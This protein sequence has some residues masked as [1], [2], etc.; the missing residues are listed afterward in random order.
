MMHPLIK[1]KNRQNEPH[2]VKTCLRAYIDREEPN[3]RSLIR[4]FTIRKQK[5]WIPY[6]VS[7]QQMPGCNFMH[8]QDDLN[9]YILHMLDAA[10]IRGV[11]DLLN[12]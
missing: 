9:P 12:K 11:Q 2:E 6:N 3:Q 8:V 7:I 10:Q 4:T 1:Q 5:P